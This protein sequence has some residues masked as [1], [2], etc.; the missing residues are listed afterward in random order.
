MQQGVES[1]PKR[2]M[3]EIF[4][5]RAELFR[6]ETQE[7]SCRVVE[8]WT[9]IKDSVLVFKIVEYDGEETLRAK[10]KVIIPFGF[11]PLVNPFNEI[12]F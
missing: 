2:C 7:E 1:D 6:P 8:V 3:G 9:T 5:L 12:T 11:P 4:L 10:L